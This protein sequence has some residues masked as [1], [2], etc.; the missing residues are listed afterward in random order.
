MLKPDGLFSMIEVDGTSNVF[1]DKGSAV[2]TFMYGISLTHCLPVGM[3]SEGPDFLVV[4][5]S[6]DITLN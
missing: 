1:K 4:L 3:N 6:L 2:S 5:A